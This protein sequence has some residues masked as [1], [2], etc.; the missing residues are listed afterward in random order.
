MSAIELRFSEWLP[1]TI[2]LRMVADLLGL[3]AS[4]ASGLIREGRFPCCVTKVRGK[5]VASV[6]DVMEVMG[7][8]DAVVRADDLLAGAE[9]A[10]RWD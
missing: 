8:E 6:V 4:K 10:Q 1:A 9:F 3:D 7:I 5:Y 2:P